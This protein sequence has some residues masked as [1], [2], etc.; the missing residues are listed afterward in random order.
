MVP[1]L[2]WPMMVALVVVALGGGAFVLTRR[3]TG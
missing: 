3:P 2:P 1:A